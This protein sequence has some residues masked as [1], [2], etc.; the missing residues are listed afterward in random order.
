MTR[1]QYELINT[2]VLAVDTLAEMMITRQRRELPSHVRTPLTIN[3]TPKTERPSSP[4]M[5]LVTVKL[6][7]QTI[8]VSTAIAS[9]IRAA[10]E[11]MFMA[12]GKHIQVNS[13]LR[14]FEKQTEI[15]NAAM[16][17]K[18]L[19]Y[20]TGIVA[21]LPGTSRHERGLAVDVQNWEE[22]G[23]YLREQGLDNRIKND[24]VHFQL[25]EIKSA[26]TPTGGFVTGGI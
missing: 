9:K 7:E 23:I 22:A 11:A 8:T 4:D 2:Y 26:S 24:E 21:A 19:G 12:T 13:S 25:E 17:R 6:G 10:D 3:R 20:K 14:T 16:E 1:I 5:S 15:Y 18:R